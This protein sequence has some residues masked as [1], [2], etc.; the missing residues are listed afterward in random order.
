MNAYLDKK[1]LGSISLPV[2]ALLN[3]IMFKET[4]ARYII[5]QKPFYLPFHQFQGEYVYFQFMFC[6]EMTAKYNQI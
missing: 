3:L 5:A 4:Y 6:T 1:K 2:K